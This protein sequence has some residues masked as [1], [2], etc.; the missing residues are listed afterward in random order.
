MLDLIEQGARI[1]DHGLRHPVRDIRVIARDLTGRS[2]LERTDGTVTTP[3]GLLGDY[4]DR[5]AHLVE[6]GDHSLGD[7]AL[8][9]YVIDLWTRMLGAVETQDFSSVDTE[10]DW[11]MKKALIDRAMAR[12]GIRIGDA[13]I[14]RLDI[15]YHDITPGTGLFPRLEAAGLAKSLVP[16]EAVTRAKDEPPETTRAAVRG[17]FIRAAHDARR[18]YTVDWVHLRL[19]DESGRAVALKD[20]FSA[21][22]AQA[23]A[24]IAGL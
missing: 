23:E 14:Q 19:N 15:A 16:A 7:D 18:D 20:P 5:A 10:I 2:R 9:A 21:T 6:T 3:L 22:H 8:A 11:V 1:P 4:R 24:L 17:A 12:G 13:Q